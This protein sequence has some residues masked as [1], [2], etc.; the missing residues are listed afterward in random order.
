MTVHILTSDDFG[1]DFVILGVYATRE[2]ADQ[3]KADAATRRIGDELRVTEYAV[4]QSGTV[5][6][7]N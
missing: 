4:S 6:H 1:F 7:A 2:L 5:H 3:A